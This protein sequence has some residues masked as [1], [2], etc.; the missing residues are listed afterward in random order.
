MKK[1]EGEEAAK[2]AAEGAA[3]APAT[4]AAI[5]QWTATAPELKAVFEKY[6]EVRDGIMQTARD[7]EAAKPVLEIVGTPDEARFAVEHAQRLVGLQSSWIQSADDPEMVEGAWSQTVEMFKERDE[8]GAEILASDGKPKLGEDFKPFVRKAAATAM[9]DY[10]AASAAQ[11]AVLEGRLKGSYPSEEAREADAAALENAKYEKAAFDFVLA[12]LASP[13]D[14]AGIKLPSLGPNATAEQVATQEALKAQLADLEAK[15]G[16][17]TAETRRTAAKALDREV[18]ISYETQVNDLIAAEVTAMKGRNEYVSDLVLQDKWINPT[19][20]QPTK[21][22]DFGARVYQEVNAKISG[23]P[24]HM[25]KLASLQ[26]LGAAGKEARIAEVNRLVNLYFKPAM[27]KHRWR[28]QAGA[29]AKAANP[30]AGN[31]ARV[32]PQS[33]G[34]IS[35]Q[36]TMD[37]AQTRTWAETEAAKDPGWSSMDARSREQLIISLAAKKRFG[38]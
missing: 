7:L 21:V 25:A 3:A 23:N 10:Q 17:Q 27:E 34:T 9:L 31:V 5:E 8:K 36:G 32:E 29:P 11:V 26:A 19:T 22:S 2:P 18:Q 4:P 28:L 14:A 13:E 1:A 33:A 30:A 6:P 15:Q 37:A 38:G 12:R 24:L 20:G 16:K 35:P